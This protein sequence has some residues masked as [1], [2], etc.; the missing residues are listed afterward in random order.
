MQT[1]LLTRALLKYKGLFSLLKGLKNAASQCQVGI[2]EALQ[3]LA[4]GGA[5]QTV[6]RI[7]YGKKKMKWS[8]TISCI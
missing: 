3:H 4:S 7:E 2:A 1:V 8:G 5:T 6:F